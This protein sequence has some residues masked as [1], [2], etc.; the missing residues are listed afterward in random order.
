M[1]SGK[2]GTLRY[3]PEPG[4]YHSITLKDLIAGGF[5]VFVFVFVFFCFCLFLGPHPQHMEFPRLGIGSYLKLWYE[6][7]MT[8]P[9]L[10]RIL[11]PLSLDIEPTS[12]CTPA[13]FVTTEPHWEL[14][15]ILVLMSPSKYMDLPRLIPWLF[16]LLHH[17]NS[18]LSISASK[19]TTVESPKS[20]SLSLMFS[21]IL[22]SLK[23]FYL[24]CLWKS[25]GNRAAETL[26]DFS[27]G[28][29]HV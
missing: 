5:F 22:S 12:F 13:G 9:P 8:Q 28:S 15:R 7:P 18:H 29:E 23:H 20:V 25:S 16:F 27:Q 21:H 26:W 4:V 2:N 17:A 6:Q 14:L 3:L 11:N 19:I 10:H 1:S 24:L